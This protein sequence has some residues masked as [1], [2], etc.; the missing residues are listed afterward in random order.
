MAF[1]LTAAGRAAQLA[2]AELALLSRNAKDGAL[3]AMA[4]ALR[5]TTDEI[6]AANSQDTEAAEAAGVTPSLID[7]LRLTEKRVHA[8]AA[9]LESVAL[10]NDPVGETITGWRRPNG[11]EIR[12]V[13]VPLGVV[14][15]IYESRPN[16][17]ADASGL[18]LKSGNACLLRGGSDA[19]RSN[20]AIVTSL[21]RGVAAAGLPE[22]CVQLVSTSE[23]SAAHAMMQMN[24]IID[25]LIPRGGAQLIQHVVQHATVPVIE[26]G[27]GN[28]HVYV[29]ADADLE[30]AHKVA[31]NAK[32]SRPGV[33]NAME[34]LLVH[35]SA[36]GHLLPSLL[37]DLA[38]Q[39]VEIRGCAVTRSYY[40][41]A[42]PAE[43]TDWEEEYLDLILAVRV[44]ESIDEAMLHIRRYGTRHSEAIITRSIQAAQR[45]CREV[46]AAAVYVNA[47][48]RFTDGE[49]FG[50]GAEIGISNQKL[51]ARGPMGLNELTTCKYLVYGDG[52]TR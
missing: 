47:S 1:D 30:M 40:P 44:V 28:C 48:T 39:G 7:R 51:H 10:L 16:V 50:F 22:D 13:R 2:A 38:A 49:E 23:R 29:D 9:G 4:Q 36:A 11:L 6:L 35:R 21:R 18:C 45:F 25:V 26:T 43:E 8:M 14:G 3:R 34:T 33:C 12:K 24:G 46:D 32:C 5:D 17:T 31:V 20:L 19:L 37:S 52:H 41:D 42:A 27:T 15:I